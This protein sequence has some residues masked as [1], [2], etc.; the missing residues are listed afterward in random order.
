MACIVLAYRGM[1]CTGMAYIVMAYIVMAY[2][3]LV[4]ACS[5]DCAHVRER[6]AMRARTHTHGAARLMCAE[7][8]DVRLAYDGLIVPLQLS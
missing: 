7:G 8:L 4:R 6:L 2:A 3:G 1:A 5:E